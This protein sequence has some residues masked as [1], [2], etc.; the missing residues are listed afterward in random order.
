MYKI[1]EY[2]SVF[3]IDNNKKKRSH[4]YNSRFTTNICILV[5]GKIEPR[6]KTRNPYN[7]PIPS[8]NNIG[9]KIIV[10]QFQL[11]KPNI[12]NNNITF[13]TIA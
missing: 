13:Y 6:R 2:A 12:E 8:N 5:C 11:I 4:V 9:T 3:K 7:F 1:T 10:Q